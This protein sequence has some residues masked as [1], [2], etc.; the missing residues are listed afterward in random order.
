LD[1]NW[2]ILEFLKLLSLGCNPAQT[3]LIIFISV[4]VVFREKHGLV[5]NDF[6][7]CLM[8]LRQASKDE[9]QGDVQPAENANT[10]ATYST[11]QL[12]VILEGERTLGNIV[13]GLCCVV[14][15]CPEFGREILEFITDISL[16]SN[17]EYFEPMKWLKIPVNLGHTSNVIVFIF[18]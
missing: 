15:N 10:G 16:G 12:S 4:T 8:E 2:Y 3:F 1:E 17:E 14:H 6:L 5:R 7:D 9:A 18:H 13:F 11:L